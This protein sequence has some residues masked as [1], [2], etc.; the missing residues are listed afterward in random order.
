MWRLLRSLE[1][2]FVIACT[3]AGGEIGPKHGLIAK[4]LFKEEF[5]RGQIV[6]GLRDREG[7]I[8]RT[9]TLLPHKSHFTVR[10]LQGPHVEVGIVADDVFHE[11]DELGDRIE[12]RGP[13]GWVVVRRD[14]VGGEERDPRG[15]RVAVWDTA[16]AY[17]R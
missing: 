15:I 4:L 12:I 2:N 3:R 10:L 7:R 8:T 6:C 16:R 14:Y 13:T 9:I 5:E 11:R 1:E 17:E